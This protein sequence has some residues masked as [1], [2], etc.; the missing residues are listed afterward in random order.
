MGRM[1]SAVETNAPIH[2][3]MFDIK[4]PA[5]KSPGGMLMAA[6]AA[7]PNRPALGHPATWPDPLGLTSRDFNGYRWATFGDLM[8]RVERLARGLRRLVPRGAHVAIAGWNQMEWSLADFAC[9]AAGL[10]SV[11]ES[12]IVANQDETSASQG[13]TKR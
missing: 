10:V 12:L 8:P 2:G 4:D 1:M 13:T 9:A 5:T 7:F 6:M 3:V 11:G